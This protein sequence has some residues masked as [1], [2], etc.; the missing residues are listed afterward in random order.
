ML[1]Y[2]YDI[3]MYNKG[4]EEHLKYLEMVLEKLQQH[5]LYVKMSKYKFWVSEIDYLGHKINV[6]GVMA[7]PKNIVAMVDWP[8]P[9]NIKSLR[10]F[11]RLTGG[12]TTSSLR[13]MA[14][15]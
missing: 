12:T 2:F 6:H 5:Q 4:C 1:V 7:D 13:A 10:G 11:F 3:L 9:T 8:L 14:P 15:W